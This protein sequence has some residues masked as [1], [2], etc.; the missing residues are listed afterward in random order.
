MI[1]NVHV[2][3][4]YFARVSSSVVDTCTYMH[5]L[6]VVVIPSTEIVNTDMYLY[7]IFLLNNT[8]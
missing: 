7:Y 3:V 8:I 6:I 4:L 2:L 1:A 5:L